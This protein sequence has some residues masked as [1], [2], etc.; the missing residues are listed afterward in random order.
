MI[1]SSLPTKSNQYGNGE[2]H[3]LRITLSLHPSEDT[4][5]TTQLTEMDEI[6]HE[7][8]VVEEFDAL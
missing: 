5:C 7:C 1:R 8:L 6:D 2:E 3:I 4:P